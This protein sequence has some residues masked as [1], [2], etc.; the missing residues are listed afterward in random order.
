MLLLFSIHE[1]TINKPIFEAQL[2]YFYRLHDLISQLNPKTFRFDPNLLFIKITRE[3]I[4]EIKRTELAKMI[5]KRNEEKN[6][7]Q[8]FD[9]TWE[10]VTY[11]FEA[12]FKVTKQ[13]KQQQCNYCLDHLDSHLIN[14]EFP[15]G[16]ICYTCLFDM[17]DT[18]PYVVNHHDQI[19]SHNNFYK[20]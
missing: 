5:K 19:F 20:I 4:L 16:C 18:K 17:N 2:P 14:N 3:K 15:I 8:E 13:T 10:N 11:Q 12:R 7:L 6:M 9:S 1:F